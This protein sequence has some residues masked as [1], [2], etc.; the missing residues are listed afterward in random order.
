MYKI[1]VL[2][3]LSFT[4]NAKTTYKEIP[5]SYKKISDLNSRFIYTFIDWEEM[6]EDPDVS[7]EQYRKYIGT[8]CAGLYDYLTEREM[9]NLKFT[10]SL[11]NKIEFMEAII[12]YNL[13]YLGEAEDEKEQ[14]RVTIRR[15]GFKGYYRNL[16]Q[17]Q[18][19]YLYKT[20]R[21]S[22]DVKFC[23]KYYKDNF[24]K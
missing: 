5:S 1:L 16:F 8:R 15:I 17:H 12:N 13:I 19:K 14:I 24:V 10:V 21:L 11:D 6:Q 20:D 22:N 4:L 7:V 23:E 18:D 2:L 3:L 9:L